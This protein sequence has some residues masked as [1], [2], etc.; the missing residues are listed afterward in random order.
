MDFF[1]LNCTMNEYS[2][3]KGAFFKALKH[4]K[5][6]FMYCFVMYEHLSKLRCLQKT[7]SLNCLNLLYIVLQS[8]INALLWL[9]FMR[10][11]DID[12][13]HNGGI[14]YEALLKYYIC[15]GKHHLLSQV[16]YSQ[17]TGTK[18]NHKFSCSIRSFT[19]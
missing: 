12:L 1:V 5:W 3:N 7:V 10:K 18:T 11:L 6:T 17:D 15:V 13:W 14:S 2:H 16:C 19:R 8:Q 4:L 9:H